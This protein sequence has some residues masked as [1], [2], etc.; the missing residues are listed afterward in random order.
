MLS[1]SGSVFTWS[2]WNGR[3]A[4]LGGRVGGT[5]IVEAFWGTNRFISSPRALLL[6]NLVL[7]QGSLNY[8]ESGLT[9]V[10]FLSE[11]VEKYTIAKVKFCSLT[12]TKQ[13]EAWGEPL[14]TSH[15]NLICAFLLPNPLHQGA[16]EKPEQTEPLGL[17]RGTCCWYSHSAGRVPLLG[18]TTALEIVA[19]L[20]YFN[21]IFVVICV[22]SINGALDGHELVSRSRSFHGMHILYNF[23]VG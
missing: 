21:M 14:K 9:H 5:P 15:Q 1:I 20:M 11:L 3:A 7:F 19:Q 12:L 13:L 2:L 16:A 6:G 10:F 23:Y 8:C 17:L 18:S 4:A 22:H